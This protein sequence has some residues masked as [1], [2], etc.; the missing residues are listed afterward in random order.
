MAEKVRLLLRG[1]GSLM[2]LYPNTHGGLIEDRIADHW[3]QVGGHLRWAMNTYYDAEIA[4]RP[5]F[6]TKAKPP[7]SRE[8]QAA[9]H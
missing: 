9:R 5:E 3:R 4:H 6:R 1:A 8:T 7:K 2:D